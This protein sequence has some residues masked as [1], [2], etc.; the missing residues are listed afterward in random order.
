MG[1][2]A[3]LIYRLPWYAHHG[4][5]RN[6]PDPAGVAPLQPVSPKRTRYGG[7]SGGKFSSLSKNHLIAQLLS[8]DF[9][10]NLGSRYPYISNDYSIYVL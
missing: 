10:S 3:K 9:E 7:T 4:S 2:G 1:H 5:N 8:R 6:W